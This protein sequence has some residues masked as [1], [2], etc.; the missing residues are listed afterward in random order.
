MASTDNIED[1][2][3]FAEKNEATFPILADPEKQMC[4]AFGVLSPR[5]YAQ[6]WT[7]YIDKQGIIRKIDKQVNPMK[8]GAQLVENLE[9][10]AFPRKP[11]S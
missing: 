1:N 8:A 10:L 6:R 9:A 4:D 3:G 5:G 2:T 11:A 7:Y